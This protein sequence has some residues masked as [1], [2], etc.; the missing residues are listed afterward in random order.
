MEGAM[1]FSSNGDASHVRPYVPQIDTTTSLLEIYY[2][3]GRNILA[4]RRA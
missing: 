2:I 1:G 4:R 3:R